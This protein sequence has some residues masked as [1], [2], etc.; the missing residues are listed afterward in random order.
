[1]IPVKI[2]FY[3]QNREKGEFAHSMVDKVLIISSLNFHD[4]NKYLELGKDTANSSLNE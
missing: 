4:K 3:S 2:N 1:M